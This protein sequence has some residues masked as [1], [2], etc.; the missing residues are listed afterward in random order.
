MGLQHC[1]RPSHTWA[2]FCS[3]SN[4]TFVLILGDSLYLFFSSLLLLASNQIIITKEPYNIKMI[5]KI[6]SFILNNVVRIIDFFQLTTSLCH[7]RLAN[8]H[9]MLLEIIHRTDGQRD[10]C[11]FLHGF[12]GF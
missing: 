11:H 3:F 9:K 10:I 12:M 5:T 1:K 6:C 4:F 8:W 7:A 2:L